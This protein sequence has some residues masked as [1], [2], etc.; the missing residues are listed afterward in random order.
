MPRKFE[1]ELFTFD[2]LSKKA[3]ARAIKDFADDPEKTWDY[4]DS[5]RLTEMFEEDL[6]EHYGLGKLEVNWS[7]GYCQGDG[8]C[9]HGTVDIPKFIKAE[10]QMKKFQKVVWLDGQGLISAQITNR[11]RQYC[12]Y[13]SMAV[14]I[15]FRGGEEVGP[16]GPREWSPRAEPE[17]LE[18]LVVEFEEYLKERVKEISREMEKSGY[19][20]IEYHRSDDYISELLESRDYYEYTKDGER[21]TR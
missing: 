9:F 21:W 11:E 12:H 2:E 8:V 10:K 20:E 6:K 13:N 16:K 3:K 1:V 5:E 18:K 7:L 19:E 17:D 14:E 4:D 15:D